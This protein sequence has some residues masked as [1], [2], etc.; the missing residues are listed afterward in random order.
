M[1]LEKRFSALTRTQRFA[2]WCT[3]LC[4]L[5][6]VVL[7]F[8]EL[9]TRLQGRRP[10]RPHVAW[11]MTVEPGGKLFAKHPTLG[12]AHVPGRLTVTFPDGYVFHATH[13][14][15]G[16][17]ITRPLTE[18]LDE[19]KDGIWIFGCSFT[20]GLGLNDDET[21]PWLLQERLPEY[22]VVS[23]AQS[24]YG[25]I[26]SLIQLREA[27]AARRTPRVAVLTYAVFHDERNALLRRW[28]KAFF[29]YNTLG[30]LQQPYA[31][32]GR[33][34]QLRLR[35][36]SPEYAGF[37]FMRYSALIHTVE[38]KYDLLMEEHVV[39]SHD[40]TKALIQAFVRDC[41]SHGIA[42]VVAGI[43]V[44]PRTTEM[45][46]F[47]EREGIRTI[48]I[49]IDYINQRRFNLLPHDNHPNAAAHRVYA[50]RLEP[51]LR[52]ILQPPAETVPDVAPT[53]GHSGE[54]TAVN[55]LPSAP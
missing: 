40:V 36:S 32:L 42:L 45:L 13:H 39:R 38:E 4:V 3:F 35:M 52:E 19:N 18:S 26:Q 44:D 25:T 27:L 8:G 12:F 21:F 1:D 16:L 14:A 43:N 11:D 20:Y 50:D 29:F 15:D 23:F 41:A 30:P 54:S 33:D 2:V 51:C 22:E 28:R 37:P 48:D 47:C 9:G 6:A 55:T 53:G 31:R 17:R 46:A 24:G 7:G 34:G 10:W 5:G 49:A